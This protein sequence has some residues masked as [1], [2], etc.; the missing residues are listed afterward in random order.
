MKGQATTIQ[1]CI[2][3]AWKN[4]DCAIYLTRGFPILVFDCI[5]EDAPSDST[6]VKV[7]Q[8]KLP[9]ISLNN[10]SSTKKLFEHI[11]GKPLVNL[12]EIS[13]ESKYKSGITAEYSGF[14]PQDISSWKSF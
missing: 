12:I 2:V 4:K 1:N 8:D 9:I 5:F 3:K 6:P 7:H 10:L 14:K 11:K 13:D